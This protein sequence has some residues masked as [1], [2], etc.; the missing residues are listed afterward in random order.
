MADSQSVLNARAALGAQLAAL[1][2]RAGYTQQILAETMFISRSTLANIET[3]YQTATRGFWS[4]ADELLSGDTTLTRGFELIE[5]ARQDQLLLA[6]QAARNT[7]QIEVD[8]E[9][10]LSPADAQNLLSRLTLP[11]LDGSTGPPGTWATLTERSN[12]LE[13]PEGSSRVLTSNDEVIVVAIDRRTFLA[14]AGL[15]LPA[16]GLELARHDLYRSVTAPEGNE[17][18][19]DWAE[20]VWEYALTYMHMSATELLPSLQVDLVTLSDALRRTHTDSAHRELRRVAALLGSFAA[21]T[22]ANLGDLRGSRRW[23]RTAK[24]A[25]DASGDIDARLWIRGREVVRALYEQRPLPV[26]LDLITDAEALRAS[27]H[28]APD[29]LPQLLCGKAQALSHTGQAAL[30]EAALREVRDNFAFLSAPTTRDT[31]SLFGWSE[32]NVRFTESYV[33][34]NLGDF[35]AADDAQRAAL[36]LFSA[37]NVRGPA[38]IQLQR[39]LCLVRAGDITPGVAH[40]QT[41]MADLPREQHIRPISDLGRKVLDAVPLTQRTR[42]DVQGF[43]IYLDRHDAA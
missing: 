4:R 3:G 10:A 12:N 20:I 23:W 13:P 32:H 6:A 2:K 21:Q 27:S 5:A 37:S 40:A 28:P 19:G 41:T 35:P 18:V 30:A 11:D 14:G 16:V 38:Q 9:R 33:Y 39:A 1:R 43:R 24:E 26:I 42:P 29:A 36:S 22:A 25:A 34:S 15:L 31:D 7:R 17:D 8:H